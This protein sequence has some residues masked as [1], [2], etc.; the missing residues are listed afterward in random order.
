MVVLLNFIFDR[1]DINPTEWIGRLILHFSEEGWQVR[2]CEI[3]E[4][5]DCENAR[6]RNSGSPV[7]TV[8]IQHFAIAH[9]AIHF[10]VPVF[11]FASSSAPSSERY[12]QSSFAQYLKVPAFFVV[13]SNRNG[14]LQFGQLSSTGL[15]Q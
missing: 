6:L 9:F 7:E 14:A 12:P 4:M 3:A 10:S 2:K 13:F 5:L 15:S 11:F 1:L 8:K